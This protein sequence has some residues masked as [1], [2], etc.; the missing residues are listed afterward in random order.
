MLVLRRVRRWRVGMGGDDVVT[1]GFAH[2]LARSTLLG[3]VAARER[4]VRRP[5]SGPQGRAL[6]MG[7]RASAG[8]NGLPAAVGV[9]DRAETAGCEPEA[10]TA[11]SGSPRFPLR[12][13]R[14]AF[15]GGAT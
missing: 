8:G 14:L 12:S 3:T 15:R 4:S 6:S 13:P 5:D 1:A 7:A 11:V 10:G 2:R 9:Q